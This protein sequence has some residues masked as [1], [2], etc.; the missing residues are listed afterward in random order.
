[1][2][3]TVEGAIVSGT[4]NGE[5]LLPGIDNRLAMME[6]VAA[7]S[8]RL[9]V[10][11][12]A[13]GS[14]GPAGPLGRRALPETKRNYLAIAGKDIFFGQDPGGPGAA[15][16]GE[17]LD[18]TRFVYLTDIEQYDRSPRRSFTTATTAPGPGCASAGFDSF[19]YLD[20]KGQVLARGTVVRIDDREVILRV[21]SNFYALHVGQNI[22]EA[23]RKPLLSSQVRELRLSPGGP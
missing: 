8:Q 20:N 23:L 3:L 2:N 16:S 22:D 13:W 18:F 11:L 19:R 15:G 10:G 17:V 9:G 4:K 7:M 5:N 1:M 21:D 14:A 12:A 6:M